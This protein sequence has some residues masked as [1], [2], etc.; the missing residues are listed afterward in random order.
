VP[1]RRLPGALAALHL[2]L[3]TAGSACGPSAREAP[4]RRICQLE[5]W[6]RP[7]TAVSRLEVTGSWS[8]WTTSQ[9]LAAQ[10]DG[11]WLATVRLEPGEYQYLLKEDSAPRLDGRRATTAINHGRE[12]SWA[13]VEDCD[14]GA[15]QVRGAEALREGPSEPWAVR[16]E[17][18]YQQPHDGRP[19][20]PGSVTLTGDDGLAQP[21]ATERWEATTGRLVLRVAPVLEGKQRL[22]V[23]ASDQSGRPVEAAFATVW[24]QAT[25]ELKDL[26]VYQVQVDRFRGTSGA[27]L[28]AP[29]TGGDW[30][31][32]TL[33]GVRRALEAGDFE[34]LGVNALWLSP[35]YLA[36]RDAHG[37]AGR[38]NF[39]YHGYWAAA[40]R[41]ID[42][43]YGG[44]VALDALVQAAHRR[45]V[46]V[47]FDV[48]PNHVH[49]DHP[50]ATRLDWLGPS[51]V[52][53]SAACPWTSHI[54]TCWFDTFLPDLSWEN[55]E[56]A[57]QVADDVA[58]WFERFSADGVRVDAVPMVPV[59]AI[60]RL[61]S[62][63]RTRFD[64]PGHRSFLLG[65]NFTGIDGW[66]RLGAYLGGPGLDGE[67]HFP[68]LWAL[69]SAVAE[70][71]APLA[72]VDQV[73]QRGEQTWPGGEAVMGLTVGNH[74]VPRFASVADRSVGDGWA[75]A[76]AADAPRGLR[77][78]AAGAG[79]DL[80]AAWCAGHLPGRRA[81]PRRLGR[82][83]QPPRHARRP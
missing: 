83:R 28:T 2:A 52:C 45:G 47:L 6:Y 80:R 20:S 34:R 23:A 25:T 73:V 40:A 14:R 58:W 38:Q 75:H 3:L 33:D 41:T 44:E 15:L 62:E 76:P 50:Y 11:W 8:A 66:G 77:P 1:T 22:R 54:Q 21:F 65:E 46:R 30:A 78:P 63:V 31:G 79:T 12:V 53:G 69:R 18:E 26:V 5:V 39:G 68:L 10:A 57:T 9:P 17:L 27:A 32:G 49:R 7:T 82:S 4:P 29:Q 19:L 64:H 56:V 35:L 59:A 70:S 81:R 42:P 61:A 24:V 43:R 16:L 71:S 36:T 55:P 51:C 37:P 48:V 74:D 67:F 72:L 60:R 13:R